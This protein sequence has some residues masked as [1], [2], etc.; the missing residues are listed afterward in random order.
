[1]TLTGTASVAGDSFHK[2]I[3]TPATGWATG[4]QLAE[5]IFDG[6][7]RSATVRAAKE[8]YYAQV[9]TYRQTVLSA[10][11]NVEDNLIALRILREQLGVQNKAVAHAKLALKLV[12]NQYKA[13]TVDYASVITS[14]IAAY[15][16]ERTANDNAGL[17]MSAEVGLIMA[18]GGG[19]N[20]KIVVAREVQ[21]IS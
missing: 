20:E 19:W 6:G 1:L 2:L 14:Q 4:L 18:L 9:A 3:H 17:L 15:S 5:T 13:G 8:A 10:F 7:F 11:Q 16:A 12:L 21:K